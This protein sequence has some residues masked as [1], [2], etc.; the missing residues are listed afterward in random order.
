MLAI[1]QS[2]ALTPTGAEPLAEAPPLPRLAPE[3]VARRDSHNDEARL[4]LD[5]GDA[6][7]V[8]ADEKARAVIIRRLRRALEEAR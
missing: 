1:D 6:L 2:F 5:I 7:E 8:A 4:M 3:Q